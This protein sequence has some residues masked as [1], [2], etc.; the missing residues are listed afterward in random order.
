M[1]LNIRAKLAEGFKI[2]IL[3]QGSAAPPRTRVQTKEANYRYVDGDTK[4]QIA[5]PPTDN[6]KPGTE[7]PN[8]PTEKPTPPTVNPNQRPPRLKD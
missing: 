4:G 8:P 1:Y 2:Q 3:Q 6:P 5:N 7:N